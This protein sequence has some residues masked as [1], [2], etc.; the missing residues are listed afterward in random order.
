MMHGWV[1]CIDGELFQLGWLQGEDIVL[2]MADDLPA[3]AEG[4]GFSFVIVFDGCSAVEHGV[5][6][7]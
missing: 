3:P 1:C 2:V 6:V 5:V 4:N 7:A